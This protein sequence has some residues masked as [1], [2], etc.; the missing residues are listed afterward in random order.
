DAHSGTERTKP[1]ASYRNVRSCVRDSRYADIARTGC[2]SSSYSADC[3]ICRIG[4]EDISFPVYRNARNGKPGLCRRPA[5]SAKCGHTVACYCSNNTGH[6]IYPANTIIVAVS[7]KEISCSIHCQA[8][9]SL[10]CGCSCRAAVAAK[11]R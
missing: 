8:E 2:C 9:G 3:S 4:N 6:S 10:Q 7:D 1:R 5:V 11:V